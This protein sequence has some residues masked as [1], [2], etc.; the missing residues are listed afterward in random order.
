M[1]VDLFKSIGTDLNLSDIDIAH[2]VPTSR[3]QDGK[4]RP[5]ICKFARRIA[6]EIVMNRRS[7]TY[8]GSEGT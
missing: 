2:R 8:G 3:R 5:I 4:P 7:E 1:R 6:K